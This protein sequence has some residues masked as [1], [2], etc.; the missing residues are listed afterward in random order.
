MSWRAAV[1]V[2]RVAARFAPEDVRDRMVREWE[3][4]LE[5]A[6]RTGAGWTVV[7]SALG[8]FADAMALRRVGRRRRVPRRLA[9][10]LSAMV[11]DARVALRG[12]RRAPAFSAVSVVTLAVGLGGVAAIYTVIDRVVL[13]PLPY[14]DADRLVRVENHVPGVSPETVWQL[15]AAQ[16]VHYQERARALDEVGLY[17]G[18]QGGEMPGS[19]IMTAEGPYRVRGAAVSASTVRLL[20]LRP[21]LGRLITEADDRADTPFVIVLTYE[22]WRDVLGGD[23][24]IVGKSVLA[25]QPNEVIGVMEP[26]AALPGWPAGIP[27]DFWFPT[28]GLREGPFSN[29]HVF[30]AVARLAPGAT[31]EEA[32]REVDALTAELPERFPDVYGGNFM[33]RY[34]FRAVLTPLKED[35][36]GPVATNL[37]ILLGGVVLVLVIACANVLNLFAVRTESRAREIRIRRALGAGRGA[38]ARYAL[39][40]GTLLALLGGALALA[41]AHWAIP[42]LIAL[43]PPDVPRLAGIRVGGDGAALV[44]LLSVTIGVGLAVQAGLAGSWGLARGSLPVADRRSTSGLHP[45]SVRAGVVVGQV[46]LALTLTVGAGLL[47]RGM[48]EL[49]ETAV[50]FS[51]ADVLA[52]DVF[53]GWPRY[54]DDTDLWA[55]YRRLLARVEALPG[56]TVAGLGDAV[57]VTSAYGCWVQG[58]EDADVSV[59]LDEEG[60]TRCAGR[61]IVTP[62]Y[63]EALGIP[64]LEGRTFDAGDIDEP[65]RA[66]VVVSQ[67]FAE[68]FWPGER[69]LG[70]G[71]TPGRSVGPYYRVVGVVGDVPRAAEAGRRPL[72]DDAVAIYYPVVHASQTPVRWLPN[73]ATLLV[74]TD[75]VEPMALFPAVRDALSEVDP[76]MPIADAR[77]MSS[78]VADAF[79][80]VSFVSLLLELATLVA[81]V[82]AAVGLYGV[83]S[84]MVTCRTREMGVRMAVGAQRGQLERMVIGHTTALVA[85]GLLLGLP[86]GLGAVR[87]AG[88]VLV[89]VDVRDPT[90]YVLAATVV[91]GV[92]LGASWIPAR[93]AAGVDPMTALRPD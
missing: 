85:I 59:R 63:F 57:P 3:A 90:V 15:S 64:V 30:P 51:P 83:I 73:T 12:L 5:R 45:R 18:M 52:V 10:W 17:L 20:G 9:G 58:F 39:V 27:V 33:N 91:V 42:G 49:R 26:G 19:N 14:P 53:P 31:L 2:V 34:G 47:L 7:R 24:D 67:A 74:R 93:R 28:Q 36:V 81:L 22:F 21:Y 16:W 40:E 11:W 71:V 48:R 35:V 92:A 23:P 13:D 88:T 56:V 8:A 77:P 70:K 66:S 84:Y 72:S 50:G 89:G 87:V 79:A 62:G 60:S 6:H 61:A 80:A 46:A 1:A 65:Q 38:L 32:Q 4:E 25:T 76:E 41:V 43:A 29:S 86:L 55:L 78:D 68:R 75:G 44:A 69:A 82:L 37:W 54:R